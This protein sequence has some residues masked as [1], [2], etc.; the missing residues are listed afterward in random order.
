MLGQAVGSSTGLQCYPQLPDVGELATTAQAMHVG[1]LVVTQ[2]Q[3]IVC[4]ISAVACGLHAGT[5][6]FHMIRDTVLTS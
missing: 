6:A 1:N 2:Q 5:W 4:N 3:L